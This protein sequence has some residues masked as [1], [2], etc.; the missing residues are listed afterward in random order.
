MRL[1]NI[2]IN[3]N[4]DIAALISLADNIKYYNFI[5]LFG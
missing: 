2:N 5:A 1:A 3:I 4:I